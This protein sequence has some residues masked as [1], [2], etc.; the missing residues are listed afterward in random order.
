MKVIA[1]HFHIQNHGPYGMS[2]L[3]NLTQMFLNKLMY[4]TLSYPTFLT[5]LLTQL[6]TY[7]P[8]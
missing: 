2:Q 1:S 5:N 3:K 4:F 6:F 7:L 8:T